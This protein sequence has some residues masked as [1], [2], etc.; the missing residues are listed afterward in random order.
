LRVV[1]PVVLVFAAVMSSAD[2]YLFTNTSI[3]LQ[4]FYS[5][6]KKVNE[7]ELIKL[8]RYSLALLV[9]IGVIIAV[10]I[11]SVISTAYIYSGFAAVIAMTAISSW[12]IKNISGRTLIF[13]MAFGF[14]GTLVYIVIIPV[15]EIIALSSLGF[16]LAGLISGG[17]YN[18]IKK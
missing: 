12:L 17:V 16:T 4:D 6:F 11:Q 3:M 8:F 9:F 2:T 5:R 14:I 15:T 10:I 1:S 18:L 7:V 13:G